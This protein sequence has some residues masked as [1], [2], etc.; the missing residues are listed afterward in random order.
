MDILL[1]ILSTFLM[2]LSPFIVFIIGMA[3]TMWIDLKYGEMA[4]WTTIFLLF[5]LLL[6]IYKETA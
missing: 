5:L 4:R 2:L 6:A 3:I 1:S